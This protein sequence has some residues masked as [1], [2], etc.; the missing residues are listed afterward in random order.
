MFRHVRGVMGAPARVKGFS[1][2]GTDDLATR[3]RDGTDTGR[4]ALGFAGIAALNGTRFSDHRAFGVRRAYCAEAFAH[5]RL[6]GTP[7]RKRDETE[8]ALFGNQIVLAA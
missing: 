7:F 1:E 5:V 8:V 2:Y 4:D 3:Q 6:D